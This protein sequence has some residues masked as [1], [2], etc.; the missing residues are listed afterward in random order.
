MRGALGEPIY[1]KIASPPLRGYRCFLSGEPR[2]ALAGANL[3]W[4]FSAGPPG[5]RSIFFAQHH[6]G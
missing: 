4:L 6:C 2:T 5:C 3:S 1:Q